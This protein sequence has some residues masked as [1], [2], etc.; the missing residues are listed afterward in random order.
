MRFLSAIREWLRALLF[1]RQEERDLE[2]ELEFHRNAAIEEN[3]RQGM[4]PGEARRRAEIRL[5]GIEEIKE[6]VRDARGTRLLEDLARDLRFAGRRL[7]KQRGFSLPI[8]VTIALGIAVASAVFALLNA[9]LLRPLPYPESDRLVTVG[10]IATGTDLSLTGLSPGTFLHYHDRNRSFESMAV[11]LEDARI[12]SD[13]ERPEQVRVALV[14]AD[15]FNVMQAMPSLGNLPAGD[16]DLKN[17]KGVMISHDLWVGRYAA[18]PA[19]IGRSIE[20]DREQYQVTGVVE[21]GFHFPQDET[22]IWMIGHMEEILARFGGRAALGGFYLRGIARLKPSQSI[23]TAQEDLKRLV[24]AL[25]TA[26]PDVTEGDLERMG[27]ETVVGSLKESVVGPVRPGLLLLVA[28]AGILL[29]MAWANA[30]NLSLL[31]AER[32]QGEVALERALGAGYRR[33]IQ[34]FL[35]EGLLLAAPAGLAGF[36]LAQFA[37]GVR[38]GFGSSEI[39]RLR[40][41]IVDAPVVGF[42]SSVSLMTALLLATVS[43]MSVRRSGFSGSPAESLRFLRSERQREGGK[44][45]LAAGQVALAL[46]LLIGSALMVRSYSR[47]A[48]LDLGFRPDGA[49]TFLLPLPS[50]IYAD[51]S[52]TLRLHAGVLERLRQLPGVEAAETATVAAFPLTPVPDYFN[53]TL[54]LPSPTSSNAPSSRALFSFVTRGYFKAMG[55]PILK[56]NTFDRESR[57]E[58]ATAILSAR[59]AEELYRGRNAIGRLVL[60]QNT[61]GLQY[62]VA[63]VVGDVPSRSIREGPSNVLYLLNPA[64]E[65]AGEGPAAPTVALRNE[66]YIVRTELPMSS[67]LPAIRRSIGEVDP[68]LAL[69]GVEMLEDLVF[70][71]LATAR[72]TML[73][74][75][76]ASTTA[77]FLG[78]IGI[79]TVLA[80][81]IRCR[82]RELGVRMALGASPGGIVAL[83]VRQGALLTLGGI[84]AGLLAASGLTRFLSSLLYDVSSSDP[85]A[86]STAALLLF[87]VALIASAIPA[88]QAARIDPVKTLRAE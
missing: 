43:L 25:P 84:A 49:I 86:F 23:E 46:T 40:E 18:D 69:T 13:I 77:L 75:V 59:L 17:D 47:M 5:G 73:L 72:L 66:Q 42:I 6:R 64:G 36:T 78:L 38:L 58:I 65:G 57:G 16:L 55:I 31:R 28:T 81:S 10:H 8:V 11:Y 19:I 85:L 48:R 24:E 12:L 70:R 61:G 74:L 26:F 1:R 87:V 80:Y 7:L 82:K 21:A 3:L 4:S 27:L 52:A 76:V 33:L 32:Q 83:V 53:D 30:M 41:M 22:E 35:S 71:S 63:G 67:L 20:I 56:G 88:R 45:L 2:E 79:Y 29:L 37:V 60:S 39:P 54:S 15:F 14:S 44:R 34:R 51:R 50:Q 62:R 68:K 9:V